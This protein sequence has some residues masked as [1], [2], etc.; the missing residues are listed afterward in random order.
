VRI[1]PRLR[2]ETTIESSNTLRR[3]LGYF[4][5]AFSK[6]DGAGEDIFSPRRHRVRRG[7]ESM[8]IDLFFD[9][10]GRRRLDQ[11]PTS[12][13]GSNMSNDLQ[14]T[15]EEGYKTRKQESLAFAQDFQFLDIEGWEGYS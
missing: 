15:L 10:I 9:P 11:K 5:F 7:F 4:S 13:K 6:P 1:S 12:Q 8:G 2:E 3:I 14:K